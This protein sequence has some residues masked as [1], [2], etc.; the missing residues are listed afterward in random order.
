MDERGGSEDGEKRSDS[1]YTS[2]VDPTGLTDRK[3]MGYAKKRSG[4]D[5]SKVLARA[6]EEWSCH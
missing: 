6:L 4:E 3:N 5:D 1:G 2:N